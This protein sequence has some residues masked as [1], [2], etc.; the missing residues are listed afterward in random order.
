MRGDIKNA[1]KSYRAAIYSGVSNVAIFSNL[2]IICQELSEQMKLE[3]LQKAIAI[4][5]IM[6]I[7]SQT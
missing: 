1:E 2:G 3:I 5:L 6:Q 4:S 7:P